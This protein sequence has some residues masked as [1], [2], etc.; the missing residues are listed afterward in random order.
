MVTFSTGDYTDG[1]VKRSCLLDEGAITVG[2]AYGIGGGS[3]TTYGFAAEIKKGMVVGLS[4][5]A[6]NTWANT[7]GSI[8]VNQIAASTDVIIGIVISEPEFT[9]KPSVSKSTLADRIAGEYL[10]A[11]TVWFPGVTAITKATLKCANAGI[12]TPGTVSILK[13]DQSECAAGGGITVN[14][15]AN[16]GAANICSMHYQAKSASAVVPIMIA[17][18]GGT[19]AAQA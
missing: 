15:L 17:F 4:T 1:G 10:R 12:V 3:S 2:S 19:T 13:I 8:L 6:A 7:D 11:A 16:S 9:R 18:L 5:D 14:D